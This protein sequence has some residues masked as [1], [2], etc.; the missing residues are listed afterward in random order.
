MLK[1]LFNSYKDRKVSA[2]T[3]RIRLPAA[4]LL[5]FLGLRHKRATAETHVLPTVSTNQ[6]LLQ[7][8]GVY[9]TVE[10]IF[11][12]EMLMAQ[13][14]AEAAQR[15]DWTVTEVSYNPGQFVELGGSIKYYQV[16]NG[17][18]TV[19]GAFAREVELV[20]EV[21]GTTL[22]SQ[23]NKT[24]S[25]LARQLWPDFLNEEVAVTDPN[26]GE[27][28]LKKKIS[29]VT[30][31]LQ[32]GVRGPLGTETELGADGVTRTIT[33]EG[34]LSYYFFPIEVTDD[35]KIRQLLLSGRYSQGPTERTAP[36]PHITFAGGAFAGTF[37]GVQPD[38]ELLLQE[39]ASG[40]NAQSLA[41]IIS[42]NR[43]IADATGQTSE[44]VLQ[45]LLMKT[46]RG[47]AAYDPYSLKRLILDDAREV[48]S[49][50][51]LLNTA[52]DSSQNTADPVKL[53]HE[54]THAADAL[55]KEE[56]MLSTGEEVFENPGSSWLEE[57]LAN[58]TELLRQMVVNEYDLYG[59]RYKAYFYTNSEAAVVTDQGYS[60]CLFLLY[61]LNKYQIRFDP[62]EI[63]S[64]YVRARIDIVVNEKDYL[65]YDIAHV[66]QLMARQ[67][68][69]LSLAEEHVEFLKTIAGNTVAAV[70]AFYSPGVLD[71]LND[72]IDKMHQVSQRY[73]LGKSGHSTLEIYKQK[74]IW[75]VVDAASVIKRITVNFTEAAVSSTRTESSNEGQ[76]FITHTLTATAQ[77][78][79]DYTGLQIIIDTGEAQG[80][81]VVVV[82]SG[83]TSIDLTEHLVKAADKG[84]GKVRM[85]VL[86]NG[87]VL[88][89]QNAG[90]RILVTFNE[91]YKENQLPL[92]MNG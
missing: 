41:I 20:G 32:I 62:L 52:I 9:T 31:L 50:L 10:R 44:V 51:Y 1:E 47:L 72:Q 17:E 86:N 3:A 66:L 92:V 65:H 35:P 54:L 80:P 8:P 49:I 19:Y 28:V 69:G 11:N 64:R 87:A 34:M 45:Q 91:E 13:T 71:V 29:A 89:S 74:W 55:T 30:R 67:E 14:S 38:R 43:H 22:F 21:D 4:L 27:T 36:T 90:A 24:N 83:Q 26:T 76:P 42:G 23:L 73:L 37:Y 25:D 61:L 59:N 2:R 82:E 68:K 77:A 78:P 70:E 18:G 39:V 58:L 88:S 56:V 57:A 6:E 60:M 15:T 63:M 7:Q 84:R 12:P 5:S 40:I 48:R 75:H 81:E 16:E 53:A 79:E 46:G 85:C 33:H